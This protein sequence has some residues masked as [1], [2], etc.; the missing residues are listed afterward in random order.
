M[1]SSATPA[2]PRCGSTDIDLISTL[3]DG[4]TADETTVQRCRKC[5]ER[6]TI[7]AKID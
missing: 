6:F 5:G 3:R 4:E 1:T 2:C 7:T